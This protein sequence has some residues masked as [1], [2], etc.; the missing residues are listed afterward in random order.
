M[1]SLTHYIE[2]TY[3]FFTLF[4][5]IDECK[6]S[7]SCHSQAT[8]RNTIGS[9]TCTCNTGYTGNAQICVGMFNYKTLGMV[10]SV[11]KTNAMRIGTY[12]IN[13]F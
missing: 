12:K 7:S 5:D 9:Y 6:V 8:C 13:I 4:L 10:L 1:L 11:E 3:N 2:V